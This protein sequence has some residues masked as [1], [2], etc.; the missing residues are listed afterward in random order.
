MSSSDCACIP[1]T[2]ITELAFRNGGSLDYRVFPVQLDLSL[3]VFPE[4]RGG[5]GAQPEGLIG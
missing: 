2:T 1:P 4:K 3:P 5:D